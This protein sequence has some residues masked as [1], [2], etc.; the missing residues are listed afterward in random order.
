[1]ARPTIEPVT[2][3]NLGEF[4][5]FLH[6]HLNAGMSPP[7]WQ[8]AL[9]P[10]WPGADQGNHGFLLRDEGRL[11]GG[12]GA[13]YAERQLGGRTEVS[14]NI[15]SWCVL[16][17]HRQHSMRLAMAV[18]GQP[19]FHFTDFSPTQIVG[20]TLR[21]LKFQPLDEGQLVLPNLPWPIRGRVLHRA[22]E[23]ESA[24]GGTPLQT[25]RD[26]AVFP[27]LHQV[28]VGV[29]GA[30]CHVIYKRRVFKRLPCA[31]IVHVSDGVLFSQSWPRLSRHLL[32]R[33][34]LCTQ[35]ERRLVGTPPRPHAVR[36]G[37]NQKLFRSETLQPAQI[38]ALYS[39]SVGMDL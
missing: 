16:G 15:T 18:V 19:G 39:E 21:F 1:M 26:H 14:C 34:L 3:A 10:R 35:V 36:T 5:Q 4:A 13:L 17:T 38:D 22:A 37:F 20:G 9:Q 24:L 11:V 28:L 29:P 8:Q 6:Q 27:W 25:W 33:G 23:V 31:G 2:A 32:A 12:I 7:Q 30:W